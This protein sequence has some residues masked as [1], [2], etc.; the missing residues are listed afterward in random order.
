MGLGKTLS[1][2]SLIAATRRQ[3][4]K[5]GKLKFKVIPPPDMNSEES[6]DIKSA[7]IT[8]K[9]Y[10]MPDMDS[11]GEGPPGKSKKDHDRKRKHEADQVKTEALRRSRLVRKSKATLL[12]CPMS[13]I[14]NWEDQIKEHWDGN[15][16]IVGGSAGVMPPKAI[17]KKWKPPK[18]DDEL[19]SDDEDFD[20][21]RIYI[22]HGQSRRSD[23][24][25]LSG[26][27]IVI[28][29]YNTL[30]L[31]FSKQG[32]SSGEETPYTPDGEGSESIDTNGD[33]SLNPRPT[34]P[35]VE[36]EIKA[37]E[38]A[39]ALRRSKKKSKGPVSKFGSQFTSVLQAIDWF[40]VVLDE[41]Q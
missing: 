41:A 17:E 9:V 10:G 8:T 20:S 29:S 4:S 15:V 33:V 30:A 35:S 24:E 1:V 7:D 22:Y 13:T 6:S 38:V 12:V 28:T 27:D 40:R 37:S 39:D 31:E 14:T 23:V 32:G 36:A 25:Y 26:F 34:D 21:L 11:D 18:K 3:A 16:E 2:V 5:W 19:S